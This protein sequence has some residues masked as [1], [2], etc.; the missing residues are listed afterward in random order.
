MPGSWLEDEE[1]TIS[2]NYTS[3][4]TGWPRGCIHLPGAYLN[5]LTR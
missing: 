4:T 1:E 2:V 3:G 5:A